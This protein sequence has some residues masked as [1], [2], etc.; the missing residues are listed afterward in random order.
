MQAP[1]RRM[2]RL[3]LFYRKSL[4]REPLLN[5]GRKPADFQVNQLGLDF[6]TPRT[7]SAC[8]ASSHRAEQ[9]CRDSGAM[10]A[11]MAEVYVLVRFFPGLTAKELADR[12]LPLPLPGSLAGGWDKR[13]SQIMRRLCDLKNAGRVERRNAKGEDSRWFP[14][15]R[16]GNRGGST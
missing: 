7:G 11:Q 10:G 1:L 12:A 8:P 16:L 3:E 14:T 5:V 15:P 13:H 6:S 4:H 9:R 2:L